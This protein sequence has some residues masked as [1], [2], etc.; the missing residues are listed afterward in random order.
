V[1]TLLSVPSCEN[2]YD[3]VGRLCLPFSQLGSQ[4]GL[5]VRFLGEYIAFMQKIKTNFGSESLTFLFRESEKIL[6]IILSSWKWMCE[7]TRVMTDY[8][9]ITFLDHPTFVVSFNF[10]YIAES[11][12]F[13]YYFFVDTS[14]VSALSPFRIR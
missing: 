1:A 6:Y 5:C 13:S 14:I 8:I 3:S 7:T 9:T 11:S 10:L 4:S 2:R 12:S